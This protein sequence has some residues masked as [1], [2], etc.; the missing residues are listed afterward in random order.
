LKNT[1]EILREGIYTSIQDLKRTGFRK[2]G[3]PKSG[4]MDEYSHILTNW[5]L[6]KEI[7][8]ELLEIT[9]YGPKIKINFDTKIALF[10]S[11]CD[12]ILNNNKIETG[13]SISVKSG[14]ILDIKKCIDANRVYLGF[15]ADMKL[16]NTFNS[17]STY[18]K[19]Q[20]GGLHGKKLLKNDKIEFINIRDNKSKKIPSSFVRS[21]N[22]NIIIRVIKGMHYYKVDN[23]NNENKINFKI[24]PNSDRMGLRLINYKIKLNDYSEIES[25]VVTKGSIQIPKDGNPI[26]LMS[27]SQSSGGYPVFGNVCKVDISKLSQVQPNQKIK[28]KFISLKESNKLIEYEKRKFMSKLNLDLSS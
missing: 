15:S 2:Y 26:I 24:S 4:P 27:D 23:F 14:D 21:N 22:Q 8:S 11:K 6:D 19:I 9:Y 20:I 7:I 3:V 28:F 5:L 16:K 17:K 13:K 12:V 25:T 10:G 18:D 1:I